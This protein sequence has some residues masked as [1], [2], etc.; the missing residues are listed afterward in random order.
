MAVWIKN[1][2]RVKNLVI[3]LL[4][5]LASYT[6]ALNI[7]LTNDDGWDAPGIQ[8]LHQVLLAAGHQ[9]TLAG[10]SEQQSGSSAAGNIGHGLVITK[11][12]EDGVKPPAGDQ[13]SVALDS[14]EGAE[15]ATA[16][17]VAIAIA[18]QNGTP[19]D[20][21]LSGINAGANT[22]AFTNF[23]GTVGAAIH[24]ISYASGRRIP[25]IA[26]S[27]NEPRPMYRCAEGDTSLCEEKN[28]QHFEVV[29]N[30]MVSFLAQLQ[31]KPGALKQ[32]SG[33]LPEGVALNI[34]YPVSDDIAGV[35][36]AVQGVLPTFAGQSQGF[37]T[38]CRGDCVAAEVGLPV[39]GG[40]VGQ[41]ELNASD[42]TNADSPDFERGYVTIVPIDTDLTAPLFQRKK[43]NHLV[44]RMNRIASGE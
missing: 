31:E 11:Q 20:L 35:K 16:G 34:N 10:S 37:L 38:G 33:L 21:L 2:I 41:L 19:V 42:V 1:I 14:G 24:G 28:R 5:G 30:W 12:L 29:A 17:Q 26:I 39:R 4:S 18:E 8:V 44:E 32:E 43:F 22:G 23:S 3:V 40:I 9:V 27:T 6:Q 7:A 25:S 36:S 13:Y 15:P